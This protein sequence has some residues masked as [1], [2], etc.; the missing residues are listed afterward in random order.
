MLMGGLM[1]R[2]YLPYGRYHAI[3]LRY[4]LHTALFIKQSS[5][6]MR[7]TLHEN[8]LIPIY[9]GVVAESELSIACTV[10]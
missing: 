6:Q 10:G 2:G 3:F 8:L 1:P 7:Q 9:I 5:H 4:S